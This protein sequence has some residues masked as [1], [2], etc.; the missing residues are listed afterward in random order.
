MHAFCRYYIYSTYHR[1]EFLEELREFGRSYD[2]VGAGAKHRGALAQK[3]VST[4]QDEVLLLEAGMYVLL[5]A[6]I[7]GG[8]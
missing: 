6:I 5:A 1:E 2:L 7:G 8:Q 4:L 3:R